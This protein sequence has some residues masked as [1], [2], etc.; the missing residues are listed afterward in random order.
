MFL[1]WNLRMSW[2]LKFGLFPLTGGGLVVGAAAILK[3]LYIRVI[4]ETDDVT[5]AFADLVIWLL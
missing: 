4:Q 3:T 1:Y 2:R 5:W